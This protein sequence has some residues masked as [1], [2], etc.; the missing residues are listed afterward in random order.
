MRCGFACVLAALAGAARMTPVCSAPSD[1][2]L[3]RQ[4]IQRSSESSSRGPDRRLLI[5]T[6]PAFTE[7][8]VQRAVGVA[9][10]KLARPGCATVYADFPLP[11]GD[12]PR[13]R[14][15]SMGL[16]PEEFLETLVFVDGSRERVCQT[17]NAGL[18]TSPGTRLIR[19][20]PRFVDFQLRN[21]GMSGVLIIHESLHSLGLGENPPTSSE[22]TQRVERRCW[23][24]IELR[25]QIRPA[26]QALM[27]ETDPVR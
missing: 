23:K 15:D 3:L 6:M 20:C 5:R 14:L 12:T 21:P 2:A 25:A 16:G 11:D 10:R 1:S 27:S 24:E 4:T 9:V 19:V 22:I 7:R 13:S 18:V 8:A 17:G 26:R